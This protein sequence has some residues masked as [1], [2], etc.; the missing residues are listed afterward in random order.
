MQ[1]PVFAEKHDADF[2]LVHVERD[3]KDAARKLEELFKARARKA[4]DPGDTG[5]NARDCAHFVRRQVGREV[6]QSLV[7]SGERAVEDTLKGV[8]QRAHGLLETG[9]DG[10]S[11]SSL[12]LF[13]SDPR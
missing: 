4:G 1:M 10:A 11:R 6:S 13:S 9:L 8:G 2:I 12:T 3:T 5:G 7:D